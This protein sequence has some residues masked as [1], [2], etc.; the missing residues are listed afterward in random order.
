MRRHMTVLFVVFVVAGLN[1]YENNADG[2]TCNENSNISFYYAD[3]LPPKFFDLYSDTVEKMTTEE[4]NE[5][6]G[7]RKARN[8]L[9]A[10]ARNE[11]KKVL[12]AED[13]NPFMANAVEEKIYNYFVANQPEGMT[14]EEAKDRFCEAMALRDA[15]DVFFDSIHKAEEEFRKPKDD[16]SL[17]DEH[18]LMNL[19]LNDLIDK[20]GNMVITSS[21]DIGYL[22]SKLDN[23]DVYEIWFGIAKFPNPRRN[24]YQ[25]GQVGLVKGERFS[26]IFKPWNRKFRKKLKKSLIKVI[27]MENNYFTPDGNV[28]KKDWKVKM[29]NSKKNKLPYF[30]GLFFKLIIE[31]GNAEF[32][33]Q[34]AVGLH[35]YEGVLKEEDSP[36]DSPVL[37]KMMQIPIPARKSTRSKAPIALVDFKI[38]TKIMEDNEPIQVHFKFGHIGEFDDGLLRTGK[39]SLFIR[40][41]D[42][43]FFKNNL[44]I[45][46]SIPRLVGKVKKVPAIKLDLNVR[47]LTFEYRRKELQ[48][49][50]TNLDQVKVK[51]LF[52]I[53][54]SKT[55]KNVSGLNNKK[56]A[57]EHPDASKVMELD[58]SSLIMTVGLGFQ[59]FKRLLPVSGKRGDAN[60]KFTEA[61]NKTIEEDMSGLSK[62][63]WQEIINNILPGIVTRVAGGKK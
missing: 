45:C 19:N 44:R 4:L 54:Q 33:T 50:F 63:D 55:D 61:V 29:I 58:S 48:N 12:K 52:I 41:M 7:A 32:T 57:S 10:K 40:I 14:P 24:T 38:N 5:L 43:L 21:E 15:R 37:I 1:L 3:N 28:S 23:E 8:T 56:G 16:D 36:V 11:Q 60:R 20:I 34:I 59:P 25:Y 2:N 46:D 9:R 13:K 49:Q 53:D 31:K 6:K 62:R 35:P 18:S 26:R 47:E 51:D 30:L 17:T 39:A 27:E 42:G 22:K